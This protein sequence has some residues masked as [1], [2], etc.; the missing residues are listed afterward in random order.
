MVHSA[1]QLATYWHAVLFNDVILIAGGK[2]SRGFLNNCLLLVYFQRGQLVG[3]QVDQ[4]DAVVVRV[5]NEQQGSVGRNGQAAWLAQLLQLL[6]HIIAI[7]DAAVD[8]DRVILWPG[9]LNK[10]KRTKIST[11]LK[12]IGTFF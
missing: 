6:A 9:D 1:A 4:A 8:C 10:T 12:S 7:S 3:V 2:G 5:G 11:V